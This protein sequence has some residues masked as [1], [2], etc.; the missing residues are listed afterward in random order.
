MVD[1]GE[2][3]DEPVLQVE[4]LNKRFLGAWANRDI[5]FDVLRGEIHCLLGENGAGK[6]TLSEC[7]YG[8]YRPTS[9]TIRFKGEVLELGSPRDA[10]AAGIGMV[11]QHFVLAPALSV[12]E[13]VIVGT[14]LPFVLNRSDAADRLKVLCADYGVDIDPSTTVA[15]LSVGQRQWVEIL[16]ALYVGVDLLILDEPT[17]VLTPMEVERL[18]TVIHKMKDDGLSVIFITHKLDEVMSASDRVTTLRKGEVV[19]TVRTADVDAQQLAR[20]MVG[21][22]VELRIEKREFRPASPMLEV[23]DIRADGDRGEEALRGVSFTVHEGEILGLAGVSGNGQRE[24]FD[25]I[26]GTR[27]PTSGSVSVGGREVTELPPRARLEL[28]ISSIPEDRVEEGLVMDFLVHQNMILGLH[29]DRPYST[30]GVLHEQQAIAFAKRSIGEYEIATPSPKRITRLLSGGNL[31]KIILARELSRD[32]SVIIASQPTRGLDISATKYVH[33]QLVQQRERG[34]AVL[35]VSEDLD[36][37]FSLADRIAVIF[38]G[39]I[40]D[41]VDPSTASVHDVGLLMAGV[42]AG[43]SSGMAS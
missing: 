14:E 31:Q 35:L 2:V 25:A 29:R 28:G 6:T 39:R 19:G 7:L 38:K 11:H 10:I 4:G 8:T 42:G 41:I 43:P 13:N 34:A 27:R 5:T 17:A 40:L 33:R 30:F 15:Q 12:L 37:I 22:D 24:L 16:K 18:F 1:S 9:G 36:E 3:V 26:V 20:M 21:R 23:K 32:P